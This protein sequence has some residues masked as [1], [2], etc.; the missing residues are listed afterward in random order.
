MSSKYEPIP[1]AIIKTRRDFIASAAGLGTLAC[2]NLSAFAH[3][4]EVGSPRE[5]SGTLAVHPE[6]STHPMPADFTG[7]SYESA[8]L[9]NPEYFSTKTKQL[10]LLFRELSPNGV[11]RIGGSTVENTTYSDS[12]FTGIPPFETYGPSTSKVKDIN[13]TTTIT[14]LTNLRGFLDA[15]GW[16][17]LYGLNLGQGTK[18]NAVAEAKAAY[19]ILG[20]RLMALQ[21]GNEADSY[22]KVFR[23]ANYGIPDFMRDWN[24]FH[25]SILESVPEAKFAGSDL[26]SVSYLAAFAAE[27]TKHPDVI[28]LTGH[29]YAMGPAGKPGMTIENLLRANP[30]FTTLPWSDT[31][32]INAA[33]KTAHLPF[34]FTEGNS[35]WNG[36]ETG[37]SNAFAS[38]LWAADTML[39][40][41]NIGYS[42]F[43]FHGGGNGEYA[44]IVGY[45]STGLVVRPEY[46]GIQFAQRFAGTTLLETEL[47]CSSDQVTA[48]AASA[49]HHIRVAVINKTGSKA[50]LQLTGKVQKLRPLLR[51]TAPAVDATAGIVLDEPHESSTSLLTIPPYSAWSFVD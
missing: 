26:N 43:N 45:P 21:I 3:E 1:D 34:R 42:G 38:A 22:P 51:L 49:D 13:T 44:P 19:A 23:P 46:F 15:T 40:V 33:M 28:L 36:G 35:C 29:Y 47:K 24:N 31:S 12:P 41:A 48:Y 39:R 17:C 2:L 18:E 30:K 32:V 7:L 27:A 37:V 10:I 4:G 9:A 50:L 5:I 16:K 8:Q 20:S 11:L 6:I 25:S 14:A